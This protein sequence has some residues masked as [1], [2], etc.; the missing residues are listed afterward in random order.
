MGAP[1]ALEPWARQMGR[2]TRVTVLDLPG[3]GSG[4]GCACSSTVTVVG[5]AAARWLEVTN[6]RGVVLAGHSSGSQSA[7][8][9]AL[10]SR[11]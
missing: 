10:R 3:W 8:H 2:W 9:A 5:A 6:T 7:L 1:L 4:R 11:R